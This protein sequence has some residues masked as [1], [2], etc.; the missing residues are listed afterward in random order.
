MFF[1][2]VMYPGAECRRIDKHVVVIRA[3]IKKIIKMKEK[4]LYT[5]TEGES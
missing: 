4:G 2:T 3:L 5:T 1:I